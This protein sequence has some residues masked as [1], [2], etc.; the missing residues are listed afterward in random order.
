MIYY[1]Q[2]KTYAPYFFQVILETEALAKKKAERKKSIGAPPLALS[3]NPGKRRVPVHTR[4]AQALCVLL[5][6]CFTATT[7]LVQIRVLDPCCVCLSNRQ[8]HVAMFA[9]VAM[10]GIYSTI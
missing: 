6:Q 3:M 8:I 5:A 1:E 2:K 9:L 4:H 10:V 7:G